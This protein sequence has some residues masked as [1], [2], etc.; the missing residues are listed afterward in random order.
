LAASDHLAGESQGE[1]KRC[2]AR[3]TAQNGIEKSTTHAR[4]SFALIARCGRKLAGGHQLFER[5]A[6]ASQARIGT[7]TVNPRRQNKPNP[8]PLIDEPRRRV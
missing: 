2:S 7:G 1:L 4:G 5:L 3:I 6:R 8:K